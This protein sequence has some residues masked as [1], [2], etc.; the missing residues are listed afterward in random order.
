MAENSKEEPLLEREKLEPELAE[1]GLEG[2]W[3]P[4]WMVTY[5]DMTTLLMTFFVL[6]YAIT[7]MNI[8]QELLKFREDME[9]SIMRST[10]K[11]TTAI[12]LSSLEDDVKVW[13]EI[14]QLTPEQRI[15]ISELQNLKE[16]AEEVEDYLEKGELEEEVKIKLRAEDVVI[17]PSSPLLFS[18]GSTTLKSSFFPV[19]DKIAWLLKE[20][21]A[22]I[23][24]EGHTDDTPI[25][26]RH[27]RKFP[28]NWE[29]SSARA[30]AVGRYLMDR[31]NIP[32]RRI[33]ISGYGPTLPSAP[34]E[35]PEDKSRNR[36]VEFHIFI[37][38][39]TTSKAG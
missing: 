22:S 12:H 32:P 17:V 25:H 38:S 3:P 24:I 37:T 27:R 19:L 34:N 14:T 9:E 26:P 2:A 21:N 7:M 20:T 35:D 5:S 31:H 10:S 23:R 30:A 4:K 39:E 29:L 1:G 13:R 16:K 33:S 6:W 11:R 28:S 18:E 15:A 36:R 8:P